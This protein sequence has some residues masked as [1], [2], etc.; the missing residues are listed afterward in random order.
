M[1]MT[2][3]KLFKGLLLYRVTILIAT[4]NVYITNRFEQ[5]HALIS[6]YLKLIIICLNNIQNHC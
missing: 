3:P 6:A 5:E 1:T 4:K 2:F